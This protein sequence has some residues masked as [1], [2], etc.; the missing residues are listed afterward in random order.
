[1]TKTDKKKHRTNFHISVFNSFV[2]IA[3][4]G[5]GGEGRSTIYHLL[6]PFIPLI[7]TLIYFLSSWQDDQL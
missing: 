2:P 5:G 3:D 4:G 7:I 1:M 6:S